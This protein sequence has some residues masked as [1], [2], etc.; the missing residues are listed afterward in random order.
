[1]NTNIKSTVDDVADMSYNEIGLVL[2]H[3][4]RKTNVSRTYT[5]EFIERVLLRASDMLYNP[6]KVTH[7]PEMPIEVGD[8]LEDKLR[9]DWSRYTNP[10]DIDIPVVMDD[11]TE[12]GGVGP[13]MCDLVSDMKFADSMLSE[14]DIKQV[15]VG[16][17]DHVKYPQRD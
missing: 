17:W 10:A 8:T 1:M 3:I 4:A 11:G 7:Y 16:G 2:Y 6:I 14:D 15:Y 5:V 13:W 9:E 12:V